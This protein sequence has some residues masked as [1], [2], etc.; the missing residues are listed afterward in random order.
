MADTANHWTARLSVQGWC[1]LAAV[2]AVAFFCINIQI[3]SK[4]FFDE[5]YYV[6]A[7][8]HLI[9][10]SS[11]LNQEHPPLAKY[12]IALG[13]RMFGDNSFGWRLPSALFGGLALFGTLM[14]AWEL[15]RS[16]RICI[17]TGILLVA[18]QMLFVQSRI[19]MLDV[20]M[21]GF[22]MLAL[23]Q[24]AAAVRAE[25]AGWKPLA[26]AGVL[27][28]LAM[29]CKWTAAPYGAALGL[30]FFVWRIGTLGRAAW[31]PVTLLLSR[32][33]SPVADTSLLQAF[34][35]LGVLPAIV[36]FACFLPLGLYAQGAIPP[37]GIWNYQLYMEARQSGI[38]AP[39][40]Y[41]SLWWQWVIDARPIWYLY[42]LS[43]GAIRGVLLLGNPIVM[44]AGLP[45]LALSVIMA[46]R[47]KNWA[48][49]VPTV[50]W[51]IGVDIWIVLPKAVTFYHHYFVPSFFLIVALAATLEFLW[52]RDRKYL[53]PALLVGAAVAV[54]VDFYPII[55]A[56]KL[57][58]PQSFNH[59]MWLDSWR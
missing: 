25:R 15:Y 1:A 18:G 58:D 22:L 5:V 24:V 28:G 20:F 19:A 6:P 21:A 53:A 51:L 56:M 29:A 11:P 40:R 8:R 54:F 4:I 44:W 59:W 52:L 41:S 49:C 14:F 32:D 57:G 27:T 45:A 50:L 36:Y 2:L 47:L 12:L 35:L 48:L 42:E 55:A 26:W 34:L 43:D 38:M 13:I 33:R 7:A 39:H 46:V 17:L 16:A 23:W 37:S 30:G 31:N 3:P 10:L 9:D